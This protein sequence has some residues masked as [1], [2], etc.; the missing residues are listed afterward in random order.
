[1]TRALVEQPA[2]RPDPFPNEQR[3]SHK[4]K[5][6]ETRNERATP[7]FVLL[8]GHVSTGHGGVSAQPRSY[9]AT[10][11]MQ[12]SQSQA[13]QNHKPWQ[14]PREFR[15]YIQRGALLDSL[16]DVHL[17]KKRRAFDLF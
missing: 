14:H 3:F 11:T 13:G 6:Q 7:A 9:S 5:K 10:C 15:L 2:K 16:E 4:N 8:H 12:V 1:M 17:E